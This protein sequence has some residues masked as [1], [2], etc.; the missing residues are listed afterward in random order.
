[1]NNNSD[2][3][4]AIELQYDELKTQARQNPL[5]M[6]NFTSMMNELS[7]MFQDINNYR[8]EFKT[9]DLPETKISNPETVLHLQFPDMPVE[10][11][12][13]IMD[14]VLETMGNYNVVDSKD[15]YDNKEIKEEKKLPSNNGSLLD[16]IDM[17]MK[18]LNRFN[19][20]IPYT[21]IRNEPR[22]NR[23]SRYYNADDLLNNVIN[24]G[25]FTIDVDDF[26]GDFMN[27]F[28]GNMMNLINTNRDDHKV[29]L[30]QEVLNN[31]PIITFQQHKLSKNITTTENC[32]ICFDEYKDTDNI[33]LLPCNHIFHPACINPWLSQ[34]SH[35]CPLCRYDCSKP[36]ANAK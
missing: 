27:T 1:M 22:R 36:I 7:S 13:T 30:Q 6:N 16:S 2:Y 10:D 19:D 17:E 26:N 18:A 9:L 4:F 5:L 35:Q 11:R 3:K 32:S 29:P 23:Y 14:R 8:D 21:I 12:E 15:N 34:H 31:M 25:T 20:T 24:L 33:M 28:I